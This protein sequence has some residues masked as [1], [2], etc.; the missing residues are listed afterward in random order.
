MFLRGAPLN[1]VR[2]VLYIEILSPARLETFWAGLGRWPMPAMLWGRGWR[3]PPAS[4]CT[5]V[6][7]RP[8]CNRRRRSRLDATQLWSEL[9]AVF[10]SLLVCFDG[11]RESQAALQYSGLLILR[12]A[13]RMRTGN[14]TCCIKSALNCIGIVTTLASCGRAVP[15][16][17]M[18]QFS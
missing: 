6:A 10:L 4:V 9:A 8:L 16:Q 13:W 2:P 18:H 3:A 7:C 14:T 12:L 17:R 11:W 15:A 1:S 5:A